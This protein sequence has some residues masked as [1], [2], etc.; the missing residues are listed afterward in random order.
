MTVDLGSTRPGVVTGHSA[1]T[2][3]SGRGARLKETGR[4][5]LAQRSAQVGLV[6]LVLLSLM[7]IFADVIAPYDPLDNLNG[8]GEPGRRAEPCIH[9]LYEVPILGAWGCP[10]DQPETY[11]GTDGNSRDIFSR[12]VLRGPH[13]DA[14]RPRGG[15]GRHPH[16]GPHRGHLRLRGWL[17]GQYPHAHDGRVAGLPGARA[18]H[19]HRD[20]RGAWTAQRRGRRRRRQHPAVRTPDALGRALHPRERLR[21]G[22]AGPGRIEPRHPDSPHHPQLHH[23]AH[24]GRFARASPRPSWRWLRSRSWASASPSRCPSGAP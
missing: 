11:L 3:G 4:N 23:A 10:A 16:R 21:D 14:H 17:V 5:I 12:V 24:R 20:A 22:L 1:Q 2:S 19:R 18:G 15:G 13:L 9:A 6:L 7:A 8:P